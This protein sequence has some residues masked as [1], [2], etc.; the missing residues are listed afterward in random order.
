MVNDD[1]V[2]RRRFLAGASVASVVGLSGCIAKASGDVTR[3]Y[4]SGYESYQDGRKAANSKNWKD[5]RAAYDEA[6][7]ELKQARDA[8][9]NDRVQGMVKNAIKVA[10]LR[11]RI[12][13]H[14][15]QAG[16][17]M[18]IHQTKYLTAYRALQTKSE[19]AKPSKVKNAPMGPL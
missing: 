8:A 18:D 6:I 5:A 16:D 19:P 1:S 3:N 12:A 2:T 11:K 15:P 4:S 13:V 10:Q 14:K 9:E 7:P 17:G